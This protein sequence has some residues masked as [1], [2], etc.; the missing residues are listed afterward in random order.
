M[1]TPTKRTK[2]SRLRGAAEPSAVPSP[3]PPAEVS[4]ALP[5]LPAPPT[6][7]PAQVPV[8]QAPPP[9][10]A[11]PA[12]IDPHLVSMA[13]KPPVQEQS[14]PTIEEVAQVQQQSPVEDPPIAGTPFRLNDVVQVN[15]PSSRHYGCFFV[16]A[17]ARHGKLHGWY[18]ME[19]L[20]KEFITVPF[21]TVHYIGSAKVRTRVGCSPKW[22]SDN[23]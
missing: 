7:G 15:D 2:T 5:T 1:T 16:V 12:G 14:P 6:E 17:D 22:Q 23:R 11:L 9:A 10:T 8:D 13:F 20:K 21:G 4:P 3:P 19:G 18:M